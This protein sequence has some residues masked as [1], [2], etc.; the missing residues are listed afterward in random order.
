MR[1][2]AMASR[3]I[4]PGPRALYSC[5]SGFTVRFYSQIP[6]GATW[7]CAAMSFQQQVPL[8]EFLG[9]YLPPEECTLEALKNVR[10]DR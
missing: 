6:A 5:V 9:P 4:T 8:D 10:R 2:Q 3:R 1:P 7:L